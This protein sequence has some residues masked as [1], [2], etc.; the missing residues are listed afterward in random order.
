MSCRFFLFG[1]NLRIKP[2]LH[3]LPLQV[4]PEPFQT[5][6]YLFSR[7]AQKNLSYFTILKLEY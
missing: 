4:E 6:V 7:C 2:P 1:G 3:E 5:L